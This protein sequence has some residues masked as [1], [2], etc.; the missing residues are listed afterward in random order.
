MS[1][2]YPRTGRKEG[3]IDTIRHVEDSTDEGPIYIPLSWPRKR[4]GKFYGAS[5]PEWQ[6][7]IKLSRDYQKIKSLKGKLSLYNTRYRMES[8]LMYRR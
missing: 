2:K 8:V 4:E 7:F 1:E 6:E 3:D 5:D